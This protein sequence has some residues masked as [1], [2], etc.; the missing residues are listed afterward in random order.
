MKNKKNVQSLELKL[1]IWLGN[2]YLFG[3]QFDPFRSRSAYRSFTSSLTKLFDNGKLV[4]KS[5]CFD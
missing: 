2:S 1:D 3:H 4:M 5:I